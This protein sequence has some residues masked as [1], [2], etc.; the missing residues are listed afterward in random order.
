M[1]NIYNEINIETFLQ[2]Y[3]HKK[4]RYCANGGNAGDAI[5]AFA[6]Y[7]LFEKLHLSFKT[8][9]ST[10]KT[11]NEIIFFSGGG[12]LIENFYNDAYYF[13]Q[14]NLSQNK[15]II[16]LPHTI[17]GYAEIF[18]HKAPANLIVICREQQSYDRLVTAGFPL[19]QLYIAP[20]LAFTLP[21]SLFTSYKMQKN[22]TGVANCFRTDGE[23][24]NIIKPTDN[25]DISF[26]W[27]GH[28]WANVDLAK[29]VSLSL[30]AYLSPFA[31]VRTNRL[32]IAILAAL[33]GKQVFL[34]PNS[35]WKNKAIYEYT[36]Q[37]HFPNVTFVNESEPIIQRTETIEP[38]IP[39]ATVENTDPNISSKKSFTQRGYNKLLSIVTKYRT[40]LL[41]LGRN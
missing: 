18:S 9:L 19:K 10:E 37:Q 21:S 17:F 20:D 23:Q 34:Y 30:A 28:L 35:Y 26:S 39:N 1:S 5:I 7:Q 6:T 27:N 2:S 12:N 24:T 4:I 32:H 22:C 13:L 40:R 11:A 16:I 3:A 29:Y 31:E 25:R 36:I 15:E 14:Q 8:M 33:M 41:K 38:I